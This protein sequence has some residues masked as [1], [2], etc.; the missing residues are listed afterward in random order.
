MLHLTWTVTAMPLISYK[1]KVLVIALVALLLAPHSMSASI[2]EVTKQDGQDASIARDADIIIVGPG[3]SVQ[4]NDAIT[5]SKA[6]LELTFDDATIV[7]ITRQSKL[8]IDDF[9]YDANSGTGKLAMNVAM[10]TVRYA[11]G[12]I[13]RN[14]RQ[15]VR[16]RTP[17]AT[18]A[19]R[20]TD[21]TMTVDEIGRS[22]VILLP[23]CPTPTTCYTGEIDVSTDVGM[24]TLNRA[25]QA[26]VVASASSNPTKPKIIDVLE[27]NI[28]NMLI[29]SPPSE[30]PGGMA[31]IDQAD[32]S[33]FLEE[34][35]FLFDELISEYLAADEL[36][37]SELDIDYLGGEFLDNILDL[38][39]MLAGDE[40]SADPV[41]PNIHNFKSYIQYS[42]NEEGIFLY[43]ERPPHVARVS[44]DRWTYGYVNLSMDGILAPLQINDGGTDVIINITQSN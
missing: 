14:S 7:S 20:G 40:L 33:S 26:T 18:I 37:Y 31:Y 42:Y 22:L 44:V 17:T 2:G 39:N 9:V 36:S 3:T 1:T 11:S 16:L 6:K 35:A 27:Q 23:S 30:L 41:L 25:F 10:G 15:N 4:M 43:A 24:V 32:E 13:A 38:T 5:T 8:I 28:D 21:F 12:A 29:I 34:D 19:V